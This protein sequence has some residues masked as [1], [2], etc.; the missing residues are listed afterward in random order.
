MMEDNMS[1]KKDELLQKLSDAKRAAQELASK[2]REV[3]KQGQIAA[4]L[5]AFNEDFIR[6]FPDDSFISPRQWDDQIA[7]WNVLSERARV[8]IS[9]LDETPKL[10][11]SAVSSA[12][13]AT[14]TV[15]SSVYILCLP[16]SSQDAARKTY[17]RYEQFLERSNLV[18]EIEI[19]IRR[20][21]LASPI[22]KA[23]QFWPSFIKANRP[24]RCPVWKEYPRLLFSFLCVRP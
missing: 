6:H 13:I 4:D 19:E 10:L 8:V 12:S 11:I 21:G 20:L 7:A 2:G 1:N 24:S 23:S 5:A 17:E 3:V 14:S 9:I 18:S 22:A 15:I 16:P